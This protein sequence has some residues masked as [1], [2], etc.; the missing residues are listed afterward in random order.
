M[1]AAALSSVGIGDIAIYLPALQIDMGALIRR[2]IEEN[3]LLRL[4]LKRAFEYTQQKKVRFP[5]WWEDCA[6]MAAQAALRL[7]TRGTLSLADLRYLAVGTETTV[8]H[9]KPVAAYVEGMLQEAGCPVPEGIST[10]QIQHACAGGMISLLAVL[11]LLAV[12]N[13]PAESGVVVCS[14]I[15]RYDAASTAEITQGAGAVA[16]S[17]CADPQLLTIDVATAGYSST[18]VDDFFR[19]LGSETARVKGAYSLKCYKRAVGHALLDHCARAGREPGEVLA[20][21]DAFAL[22]APFMTLPMEAMSELVSRHLGLDAAASRAF[23]AERDLDAAVEPVGVIGNI[24]SGALFLGLATVLWKRYRRLG[25]DIVG[26]EVLLLSYGSGNT[27]VV[28]AGRVAAGAPDVI[29]SWMLDDVLDHSVPATFGQYDRWI[30][31]GD[32]TATP[33]DGPVPDDGVVPADQFYLRAI[34]E[35]GYRLYDYQRDPR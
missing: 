3:P 29:R 14:D 19:P 25:D 24:Y 2:R 6:T 20:G 16:M 8:D 10:F 11:A 35:D 18:D 4:A 13:R 9:S 5:A 28:V 31:S 27:A 30:G 17:A 34:R 32:A 26:R 21:A 12:T 7:L 23:L 1:S 33:G 15:A 22:H